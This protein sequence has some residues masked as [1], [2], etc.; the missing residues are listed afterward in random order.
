MCTLY[1]INIQ[2]GVALGFL[3]PPI[4]VKDG[5]IEEI[6]SGL[7]LMFYIVAGLCTAVAIVVIVGIIPMHGDDTFKAPL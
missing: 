3:L 2:L 7:S 4:L 1:A 5:T 6:G